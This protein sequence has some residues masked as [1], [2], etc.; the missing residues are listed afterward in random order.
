MQ[1][2]G[3]RPANLTAKPRR[4][5]AG[6][7]ALITFTA[8]TSRKPLRAGSVWLGGREYRLDRRGRA[9]AR[10]RLG[11]GSHRATVARPGYRRATSAIRA[12]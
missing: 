8:R 1:L 9:L 10:V 5:R 11:R 3:Q 2:A 4:I 12:R 7:R 6:R